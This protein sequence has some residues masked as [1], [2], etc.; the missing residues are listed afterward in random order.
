[1]VQAEGYEAAHFFFGVLRHIC[2]AF[3]PF[4]EDELYKLSKG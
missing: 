2:L 3:A 4:N 1:M